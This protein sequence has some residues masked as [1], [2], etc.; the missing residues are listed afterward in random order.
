MPV[1]PNE[2]AEVMDRLEGTERLDEHDIAD[3]VR[4]VGKPLK[5][6]NG[7]VPLGI[8]AEWMAFDFSEN[9][10][11]EGEL[12]G[13]Y[14]GPRVGYPQDGRWVEWPHIQLVTPEILDYWVARSTEASGRVSVEM[15][16]ITAR[17]TTGMPCVIPPSRPPE[18]LVRR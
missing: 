10:P 13:T 4:A 12:R 11:D 14:F 17:T 1:L 5:E 3:A 8:Q 16:F 18:R 6:T 15:G 9:C 2:L 7:S